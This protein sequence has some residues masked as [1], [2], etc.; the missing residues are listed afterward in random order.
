VANVTNW[1]ISFLKY[2]P[3][4]VVP[5]IAFALIGRGDVASQTN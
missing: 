5:L 4:L 3:L 2:I 1:I